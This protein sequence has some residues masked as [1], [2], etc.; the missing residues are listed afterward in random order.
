M[1]DGREHYLHL[2]PRTTGFAGKRQGGSNPR[3]LRKR[4]PHVKKY[5]GAY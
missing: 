5:G 4:R 2:L 1:A 3:F